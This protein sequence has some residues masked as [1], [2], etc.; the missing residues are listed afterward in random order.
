MAKI[1]LL[2]GNLEMMILRILSGGAQHG[3]GIS[4]R[5]HVLSHEAL[6]IE[7]GSLYLALYRMQRKGWICAEWGQSENNRRAKFYE[8]TKAG[9]RQLETHRDGW[10]RLCAAIARVMREGAPEK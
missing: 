5:I 7:E 4:Q 6:K 9:Q 2:Q 8:L 3:W 10:D 1:D